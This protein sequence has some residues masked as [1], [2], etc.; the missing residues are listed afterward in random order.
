MNIVMISGN[1][2]RE[3]EVKNMQSSDYSVIKFSIA[4]NDERR[5]TD[6]GQWESVVSF[7]DCEFWTKN[8]QHWLKEMHKG[9]PVVIE[10]TLK[11]EKWEQDGQTRYAVR[12]RSGATR[13]SARAAR[14]A[15]VISRRH[16]VPSHSRTTRSRSDQQGS[17]GEKN[18]PLFYH[19]GVDRMIQL[20]YSIY[21]KRGDNEMK[22]ITKNMNNNQRREAILTNLQEALKEVQDL[23][24]RYADEYDTHMKFQCYKAWGELEQ[25]IDA[26]EN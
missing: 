9:S 13:S 5:K 10:G 23:S 3:P 18:S 16:L 8:P 1:L 24:K 19:L 25:A 22:K 26:L 6:N 2:A 7:F 14:R 11:Q 20:L 15:A 4:N 17:R 21:T 12:I